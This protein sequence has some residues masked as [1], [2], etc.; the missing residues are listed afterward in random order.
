MPTVYQ[1]IKKNARYRKAL[2]LKSYCARLQRPSVKSTKN[3]SLILWKI[4]R[5][6]KRNWSDT[7][8][9]GGEGDGG[10]YFGRREK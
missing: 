9:P 5:K 1:E 8:S 7:H 6:S 2:I 10:Q 3:L 4:E